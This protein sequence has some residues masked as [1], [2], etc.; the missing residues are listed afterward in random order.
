M[1]ISR[2]PGGA[3]IHEIASE[4]HYTSLHDFHR[5]DNH[6]DGFI[7]KAFLVY[8]GK[9]RFSWVIVRPKYLN[10]FPFLKEN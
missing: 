6:E 7:Q 3:H 5:N 9:F 2:G 8:E 1:A 10:H 4:N